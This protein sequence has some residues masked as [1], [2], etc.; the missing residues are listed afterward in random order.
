MI[1]A[2]RIY[3]T[4]K[5]AVLPWG[6][7][8]DKQGGNATQ[9]ARARASLRAITGNLEVPGGENFSMAGDV[10]KIIDW[11]QLELNDAIPASQR[12][13]QLGA[14]MY[15]FFGFPGWEKTRL[16]TKNCPRGYLAAPEA[17]HSNLAHAR[18]VMNAIITGKPYSVT[19]AISLASN[20][21]LSLPNTRKDFDALKA[22]E[23]YVVMEY[24]LTPS[25]ALADYVFPASSTVEQPELWLINS[26]CMACP[27]GIDPLYERRNSYDFYRGLGIR[28]EQEAHWPWQTWNMGGG[29]RRVKKSCRAFSGYLNPVPISSARTTPGS[30]TRKPE[31]G[32]TP[33]CCAALKRKMWRD[34]RLN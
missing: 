15:P 6:Y 16:P 8:L 20:P 7:G 26:F 19:A 21:L 30:A 4:T 27:Q 13:K 14:E 31:A 25:A 17:W 2:A 5:P 22:L 11:E 29:F 1:K 33:H 23:L 18:E 12:E 34:L 32:P 10:G 28:L 3:A 9:C 24:Y